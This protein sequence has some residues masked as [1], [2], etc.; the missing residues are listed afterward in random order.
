[1]SKLLIC[2]LG[3][4]GAIGTT[5][6]AGI[7]NFKTNPR[8]VEKFLM[9]KKNNFPIFSEISEMK[10]VG[11]DVKKEN[12]SDSYH[13]NI[14]FCY[15]TFIKIK[16]DLGN[17]DICIAPEVSRT[18]LEQKIQI[19]SDLKKMKEKNNGFTLV[20]VNL[21]PASSIDFEECKN[22][23]ISDLNNLS[24][25]TYADMPY[26]LA[27]LDED[28]PFVN[29]TPNP[30]E[31]PSIIN[32][33]ERKKI[34]LCGKDGKTGQTFFK[35][36]LASAFKS[37]ELFVNGWYSTNILGN[38]DGKTLSIADNSKNKIS[39]KSKVLDSVL[40]Y[41]VYDHIVRIDYYKPRNDA[42]E[43]WDVIDLQGFL[44]EEMSIRVNLQGKDSILAAPMVIDLARWAMLL[45]KKDIGGPIK[46]LAFYFKSP[47]GSNYKYNFQEQL[48]DMNNLAN[49][50]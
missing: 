43:A 32:E 10:Y 13:A 18:I 40:G 30:I 20:I 31:L 48:Q 45:H 3:A 23:S 25:K 12:L 34:P 5:I 27:A 37:R 1:M 41:K 4:K 47:I 11:W 7:L 17:L 2:A 50:L 16:E 39:N 42:K 22:M 35:I 49:K 6:A 15:E 33:F 29:F 44:N 21:L 19:I 9:T 36:V 14:P 46:E 38:G 26:L 24:G 28:I 8:E